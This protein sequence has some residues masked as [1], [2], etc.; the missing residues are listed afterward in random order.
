MR[1]EFWACAPDENFTCKELIAE[2]HRD[3]RPAPGYPTQPDHTEK[4][5]LF[6]LVETETRTGVKLTESFAGRDV[7]LE[8]TGGG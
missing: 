3:I 7:G 2:A 4:G 5:T 1:R 6:T 8:L